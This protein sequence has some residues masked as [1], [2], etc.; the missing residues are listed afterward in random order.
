MPRFADKAFYALVGWCLPQG[1]QSAME[2][3]AWVL[4]FAEAENRLLQGG[5]RKKCLSLLKTLRDRHL[6]LPGEDP[7]IHFKQSPDFPSI[8]LHSFST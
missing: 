2:G 7:K 3:D 4:S 6:D 5:C 1:K 8:F